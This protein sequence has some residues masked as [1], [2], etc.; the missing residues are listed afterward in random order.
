MKLTY[1][2]SRNLVLSVHVFFVVS[3]AEKNYN[4][5]FRLKLSF[6]F[7]IRVGDT[8]FRVVLQGHSH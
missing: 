6:F 7:H 3:M 4:L 1:L 5:N 8:I 2:Q